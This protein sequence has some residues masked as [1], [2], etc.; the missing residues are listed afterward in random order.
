MFYDYYSY[1]EKTFFSLYIVLCSLYYT[2]Y[3]RVQ[4][5][6]TNKLP[7]SVGYLR[8]LRRGEGI[9]LS[10]RLFRKMIFA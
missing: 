2:N 4:N 1:V 10:R 9:F 6:I 7:D 5:N 8:Y 3:D